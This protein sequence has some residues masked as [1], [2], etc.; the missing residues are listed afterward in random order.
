[1]F[2]FLSL[3]VLL[4]SVWLFNLLDNTSHASLLEL[5]QRLSEYVHALYPHV[6]QLLLFELGKVLLQWV[7]KKHKISF[8]SYLL[9]KNT[10][11]IKMDES[12][13][14][15]ITFLKSAQCENSDCQRLLVNP[16]SHRVEYTEFEALTAPICHSSF[17]RH[18]F[19]SYC[20]L[21]KS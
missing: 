3:R 17:S 8:V 20:N 2:L 19:R 12:S 14:L 13:F 10:L 9:F 21:N 16:F 11:Y 4:C 7:P 15:P 18:T 1:M 5:V 6:R